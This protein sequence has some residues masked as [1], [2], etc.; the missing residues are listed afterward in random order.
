MAKSSLNS[1]VTTILGSEKW[2]RPPNG[3]QDIPHRRTISDI[4]FRSVVINLCA[5]LAYYHLVRILEHRKGRWQ[6][7]PAVRFFLLLCAILLPELVPIQLCSWL[8]QDRMFRSWTRTRNRSGNAIK[9][10]GGTGNTKTRELSR[11]VWKHIIL[12]IANLV[13][14]CAALR[15]Y[16]ERLKIKYHEATFVGN[17]NI[18]HRNGWAAVAGLIAGIAS[19]IVLVQ[20][21]MSKH[22]EIPQQNGHIRT[23]SLEKAEE[24]SPQTR[25]SNDHSPFVRWLLFSPSFDLVPG[26]ELL[27]AVLIHQFPLMATNR[28]S[29]LTLMFSDSYQ[30]F[31]FLLFFVLSWGA[32]VCITTTFVGRHGVL[33]KRAFLA[34]FLLYVY[35]FAVAATVVLQAWSDVDE[36][37]DVSHGR[38]RPWNY[39]WQIKDWFSARDWDRVYMG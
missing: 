10:S 18:D 26:F 11:W 2:Y 34:D 14:I 3:S 4:A 30:I 36:L 17:L 31:C 32:K 35:T 25:Q 5:F 20:I 38:L 7:Q 8:I 22:P 16:K 1:L 15:G 29:P 27:L 39:R 9:D 13:P 12:T 24:G 6:R 33:S 28:R 37:Y 21:L 19:I 23:K